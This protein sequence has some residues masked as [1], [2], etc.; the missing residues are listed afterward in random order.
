MKKFLR[1]ALSVLTSLAVLAGTVSFSTAFADMQ[2][3]ETG[4]VDMSDEQLFFDE[5]N[6][7]SLDFSAFPDILA[8]SG[9]D[10]WL[11]GDYLDANNKAV[12][13]A[14]AELV[15]PSIDKIT[16]KLPE[17]VSFTASEISSSDPNFYNALFGACGSA[18]DAVTFDMPE[19]FW[20][21]KNT[22]AVSP[23][24]LTYTYSWRTK[25][26]TYTIESI[27]FTP[28]YYSGFA[29]FN[30]I[31]EYKNLL[32]QAVEDFVVEGETNAEKLKDIH[33]KIA[34]FTYYDLNAQF[35]GSA[36]GSL[37]TSGSV[38]ESYS[39]GFKMICDR[40]GIPCICVFGNYNESEQ[41]AHMWNY[42]LM[43]DGYWYAIDLTWDDL[44]GENGFEYKS[45][46]FLKG[47]DYFNLNHTPCE[48][49]SV[50]KL[51]YPELAS[52]NYGE[53]PAYTTTSTTSAT[54]TSTTATSTTSTTTS[55]ITTTITTSTASTTTTTT[56][57]TTTATTTSTTTRT[58]A[59]TTTTSSTSTTT[60][61]E[62]PV[63]YR[64]GDLNHDGK[65]SIADLVYCTSYVLA[66][67]KTE[68]S[69]DLNGD[70][71]VD[72][73]DVIIMREII[74]DLI[75]GRLD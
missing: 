60:T 19:I 46:Y 37:V 54:T 53:N 30:E 61:T 69:C 11:L 55:T 67:E 35:S 47:S 27:T 4:V 16:V 28:S 63:E 32:E 26:Y 58:T 51:K 14:L 17:P 39:K 64:Y 36:L 72:V 13:D 75:Y 57:T 6:G 8:G 7:F 25:L 50:V 1:P 15:T 73:V 5:T 22:M 10:G 23:D 68:Y 24:K 45:S 21:N 2:N 70:N 3:I 74:D 49:Y 42:V 56:T 34:L 18:M 41:A 71:K 40:I 62:A 31:F 33:N 66:I 9:T 44:D 65:I 12:Y 59:K 43:E 48:E 20:L 29:D 38:C 52:W